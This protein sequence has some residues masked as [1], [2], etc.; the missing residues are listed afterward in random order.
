MGQKRNP[1][2]VRWMLRRMYEFA[3]LGSRVH[4]FMMQRQEAGLH[5]GGMNISEFIKQ[6]SKSDDNK[7]A[8]IGD[9]FEKLFTIS[10]SL[11]N[12]KLKLTKDECQVGST[13][14]AFAVEFLVPKTDN[15]SYDPP[16][17]DKKKKNK[18]EVQTHIV[19][20]EILKTKIMTE[21]KNR[22]DFKI[23][24]K[25]SRSQAF[26]YARVTKNAHLKDVCKEMG[27]ELETGDVQVNLCEWYK[28]VRL[29]EKEIKIKAPKLASG[30][31]S[32]RPIVLTRKHSKKEKPLKLIETS[33]ETVSTPKSQRSD[34]TV[35]ST[36]KLLYGLNSL[37]DLSSTVTTP[38]PS[39][40][41]RS[42]DTPPEIKPIV[43]APKRRYAKRK[44][45]KQVLN[46]TA[47][48]NSIDVDSVLDTI[49]HMTGIPSNV[50]ITNE[51]MTEDESM[52]SQSETEYT[53]NFTP[54]IPIIK[55]ETRGRPRKTITSDSVILNNNNI[56][57]LQQGINDIH[58][59]IKDTGLDFSHNNEYNEIKN[60]LPA[61]K[62]KPGRG[63]PRGTKK[64]PDV[65]TDILLKKESKNQ[66]TSVPIQRRRTRITIPDGSKI[67]SRT[68][69]PDGQK[70]RT[71]TPDG[72]IKSNTLLKKQNPIGVK[73]SYLKKRLQVQNVDHLKVETNESAILDPS[74]ANV[75]EHI[76]NGCQ[77]DN[78]S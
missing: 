58:N 76:N 66:N 50:S 16:N 74:V 42:A 24:S 40:T 46:P 8:G 9:Y 12:P 47:V 10:L 55:K 34:G 17:S 73:R 6:D 11:H 52:L 62:V 18:Q 5:L 13:N 1:D 71:K 31:K 30:V 21:L 33:T 23:L 28:F 37:D 14:A 53:N 22:D 39:S 35:S 27:D 43:A 41:P 45:K 7:V 65:Q 36:D 70:S 25:F 19:H 3:S 56:N 29:A 72:I 54:I 63:R 26:R 32:D 51:S 59:I 69:T 49:H 77:V 67:R 20:S 61:A 75:F 64:S 78:L 60:I 4:Q 2:Y 44:V 48:L 57:K 38:S 68:L 15:F